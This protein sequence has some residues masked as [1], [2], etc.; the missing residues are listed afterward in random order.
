MSN[1]NRVE[2]SRSNRVLGGVC[3]G[4]A[5]YFNFDVTLM[6]VLFVVAIMCYSFGFWLYVILWLVL[7]SE[8]TLGP[9]QTQTQTHNNYGDTIDITPQE[10]YEGKDEKKPVNGAM[11]A[12]LI[13]I[14]I[15]FVALIDNFMS[16][17][18]IWKLWPV[19]LII[20]GVV[21]LINSLKNNENGK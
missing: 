9:G 19:S 3:A 18:W 5:D 4:L 8:N 2:R 15:G 7:P 21:I 12:S 10:E 1:N 6:R 20:I 14:F 13:L 17:T 16:I 11:L